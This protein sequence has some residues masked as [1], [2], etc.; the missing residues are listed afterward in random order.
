[1]AIIYPE[2]TISKPVLNFA[3]DTKFDTQSFGASSSLTTISGLSVT[4][5]LQTSRNY[6][7]IMGQI[8]IGCGSAT[9]V[10][11]TILNNGSEIDSLRG[12]ADGSRLRCTTRGSQDNQFE[13]HSFPLIGAYAPGNTNSH[14]FT[15]GGSANAGSFFVNRS[16]NSGNNTSRDNARPFTT[17]QVFEIV[18]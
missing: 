4:M 2:G 5:S 17:L 9:S 16:A 11:A 12:G 18:D 8:S 6:F 10:I 7:L 15:L 14:T 13:C 1:M 3:F